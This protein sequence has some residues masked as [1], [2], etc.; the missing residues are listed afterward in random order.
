M[1]THISGCSGGL[2]WLILSWWFD[3]EPTPV[4]LAAEAVADSDMSSSL[5]CS[6]REDQRQQEPAVHTFARRQRRRWHMKEIINGVLAGLASI[7]AG[8]GYVSPQSA[9][10]IGIGAAFT[11]YFTVYILKKYGVD[12]VCD[13]MA[14]QGTPGIWGSFAVGWAAR[15]IKDFDLGE[16]SGVLYGGGFHLLGVQCLAIV[17]TVVWAGVWTWVIFKCMA[18]FIG[19][20]VD[21]DVEAKG[22]DVVSSSL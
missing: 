8:S 20:E 21:S 4:D 12:D 9:F 18:F 19:V 15:S 10:C 7:T 2:C 14:L 16:R 13:V 6:T 1:S 22:L 17:V 3:H 5:S 11:S